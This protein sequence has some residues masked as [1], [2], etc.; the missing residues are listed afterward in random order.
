MPDITIREYFEMGV[1]P[2]DN[3]IKV[4]RWF[5]H[6]NGLQRNFLEFEPACKNPTGFNSSKKAKANNPF[7]RRCEQLD[8]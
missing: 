7:V 2:K 3:C 8:Q 4:P 1:G 6:A 5:E